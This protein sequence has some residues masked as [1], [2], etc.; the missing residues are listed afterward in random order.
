MGRGYQGAAAEARRRKSARF[1][2]PLRVFDVIGG[3]YSNPE[4]CNLD[5]K[6]ESLT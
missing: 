6:Q 5:A 4:V 1:P 3:K 2:L